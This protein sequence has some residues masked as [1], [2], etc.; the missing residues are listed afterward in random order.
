M[1]A[2]SLSHVQLFCTPWTVA[3]QAPLFMGI[4][5]VRIL[6]WLAMTSSRGS[7]QPR[8]QTHI[9][10]ITGGFF[11][12]E[13]RG[14]PIYQGSLRMWI[15]STHHSPSVCQRLPKFKS[16]PEKHGLPTSQTWQICKDFVL[17][18]T[19]VVLY[20]SVSGSHIPGKCHAH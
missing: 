4:F 2:E 1:C 15:C 12:T 6:A 16:S 3:H 7:F 14:K 20:Y 11:T 10:C 18:F 17:I 9:F 19:W 5:H 13:P 8:G